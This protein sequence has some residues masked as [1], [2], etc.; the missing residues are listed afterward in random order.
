MDISE[1]LNRPTK[2]AEPVEVEETVA[3]EEPEEIDVQKAVVESLAADKAEQDEM[4]SSLR[5]VKEEQEQEIASLHAA[6]VALQNEVAMLREKFKKAGEELAK[7]GELLAKNAEGEASNKIALIDRNAELDDRFEGETRD[8]VLEVLREGR[9]A[10]EKSG[11]FRRAQV[12]ESV[13][14]ANEANGEL[15]RRRASLEKL[16]ADNANIV[17]GTVIEEL[18]KRGLSHKNGE[19]Y[20]L[21]SEILARNYW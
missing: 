2:T 4:I 15:A 5:R 12:L 16:F 10:A 8:H 6:N 20:L 18:K 11:R 21:P 3:F 17:S 13:L 1:F 7:I 19:D 14:V 9:D